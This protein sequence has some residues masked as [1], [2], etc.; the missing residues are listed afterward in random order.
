MKVG[1]PQKM[2]EILV[3][4]H[5]ISPQQLTVAL[6][7]VKKKKKRLGEILIQTGLVTDKVICRTVAMQLGLPLAGLAKRQVSQKVLELV[8]ADFCYK[9]RVVPLGYRGKVLW[10]AMEDPTEYEVIKDV[11][12]IAGH[13]V[14]IALDSQ[15]VILDFL[16][17]YYPP[18]FVGDDSLM[19]EKNTT[20]D[21]VQL[22]ENIDDQ[23]DISFINLE[24]AAR[25]GVIRHLTNGI[26]ANAV[27]QNASDIHIEPQEDEVIVR[28]RVDG[29]MR[30]VMTF[31]KIAHPTSVS[32]IK[33]MAG[34]D[35]TE[36][37]TPQDGRVRIRIME[38]AFDLRISSLPTYYGEKIVI[39]ILEACLTTP[40]MKLGME[41]NEVDTF[42]EMLS[43]PQ[44]MIIITGPTGSGKTTTLYSALEHIHSPE[45][46]I[47][48]IED[49]VEYSLA[50]I[51]QVQVNT[52]TGMTFA[53]GLKSLL[54]QDPD[55]VMIG[56]IR[57]SETASIA[58]QIAQT[59]HLVLTTLHTNDA[60]S[61]VVRLKNMGI[62]PF[63][64]ASSLLCV[65]SQRL[66]RKIHPDCSEPDVV[67]RAIAKR[68]PGTSSGAFK[69][70]RGCADCR[71]TGYLGRLGLFEM[72]VCNQEI[73]SMIVTDTYT[74]KIYDAARRSGMRS[75]THQGMKKAL[76]G[77][78]TLEE[79]MR[80]A[81]PST[82]S[83]S[84][85]ATEKPPAETEKRAASP[86]K[87]KR[88][89]L[90]SPPAPP[91]AP[92][93][94]RFKDSIMV[95]DDDEAIQRLIKKILTME[96]YDVQV[97]K[98]ARQ[99]LI[100]IFNEPPDLILVDY[101]MPGMNGIQLIEKLRTHSRMGKIPVIMLTASKARETE[102]KALTVG[103]DDWISK[104]IIK[105]RLVARIKRFLAK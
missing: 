96:F 21:M 89:P 32:R 52:A 60:V 78:T 90:R 33:I 82:R 61:A 68:I 63:W 48:T 39:R 85:A 50:G 8:P 54:R 98:S 30:D 92:H 84:P 29:I 66:V 95:V 4:N 97:A 69:R 93:G 104:P 22:V 74:G 18:P 46:N 105:A 100:R 94:C 38:R 77:M 80:V 19:P 49:P 71:G 13:S 12:F 44:G 5:V 101:D 6:A 1:K 26:I 35:I 37:R 15:N 62:E 20:A 86:R 47:V 56:E 17:R 53:K 7:D 43:R 59:G 87:T 81:P 99:A 88:L 45:I 34:L 51:N 73:E 55:V 40:L 36:R 25:G 27:K 102:V 76:M 41:K 9:H 28:F 23:D 57:D 75:L 11:A 16:L 72:F 64:I 31:T 70:G 58:F 103:A 3:H 14:K 2:G 79:V 65:V 24:K 42:R 10:V 67:P 83:Q 91:K